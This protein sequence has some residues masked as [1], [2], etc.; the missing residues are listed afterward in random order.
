[1]RIAL[2]GAVCVAVLAGCGQTNP[3]GGTSPSATRPTA[4]KNSWTMPD[5]VGKQLQEAQDTI[6]R[7]TGNSTFLTRSHDATGKGRQQ[8]A[9][10]NWKVCSQNVA[11]GTAFNADTVIDFGAVKTE[12]KCG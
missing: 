4:A 9:D 12:E 6:Q 1:M 3:G 10:R 8:V 7:V 2:I 11:A 5:L